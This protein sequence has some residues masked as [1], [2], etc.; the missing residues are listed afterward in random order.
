[1]NFLEVLNPLKSP[2]AIYYYCCVLC[3]LVNPQ[4]LIRVWIPSTH[5]LLFCSPPN[6]FYLQFLIQAHFYDI[7][8]I[9]MSNDWIIDLVC[10]I[11]YLMFKVLKYLR[12]VEGPMLKINNGKHWDSFLAFHKHACL[13]TLKTY[14]LV[15]VPIPYFPRI[16]LYIK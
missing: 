4:Q 5:N 15:R 10:I 3:V 8:A 16:W 7:S 6:S 13:L 11:M 12:I 14:W 2:H 1:M 9:M